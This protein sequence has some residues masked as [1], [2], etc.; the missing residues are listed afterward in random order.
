MDQLTECMYTYQFCFFILFSCDFLQMNRNDLV[1]YEGLCVSNLKFISTRMADYNVV[2]CI[3]S[4]TNSNSRIHS[5]IPL[6]LEIFINFNLI[7][8]RAQQPTM[9]DQNMNY[10]IE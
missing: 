2:S 9:E 3:S 5:A 7:S 10:F 4:H 1:G 6:Y 8:L